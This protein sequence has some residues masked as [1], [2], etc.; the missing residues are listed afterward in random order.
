MNFSNIFCRSVSSY[1][2]LLKVLGHWLLRTLFLGIGRKVTGMK[3]KLFLPFLTQP[4]TKFC[5]QKAQIRNSLN[6]ILVKKENN[7]IITNFMPLRLR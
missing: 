5:T 7:Y 2:S 4:G 1:F 6:S 3:K